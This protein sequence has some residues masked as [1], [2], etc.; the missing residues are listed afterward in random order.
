MYATQGEREM[1]GKGGAKLKMRV[2]PAMDHVVSYVKGG[3]VFRKKQRVY[4]MSK[5]DSKCEVKRSSGGRSPMAKE[6]RGRLKKRVTS[7]R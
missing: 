6:A 2:Q 5:C 4:C 7:L 1:G 3:P